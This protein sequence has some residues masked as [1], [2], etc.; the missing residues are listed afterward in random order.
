MRTGETGEVQ[1]SSVSTHGRRLC[2]FLEEGAKA[3]VKGHVDAH[4][5]YPLASLV[6]LHL[7]KA[8]P[9]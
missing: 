6:D 7:Y 3:K 2:V 1:L 5:P 4:T 8:C 9:T